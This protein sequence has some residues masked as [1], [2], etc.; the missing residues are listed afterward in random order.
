VVVDRRIAG[1]ARELTPPS[2][3]RGPPP[4][5]PRC[6]NSRDQD[7]QS[8]LIVDDRQHGQPGD[9]SRPTRAEQRDRPYRRCSPWLTVEKPS[10]RR[11]GT[12]GNGSEHQALYGARIVPRRNRVGNYQPDFS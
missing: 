8:G 6:R 11:D 5:E 12:L 10:A 9:Q 7:Q 3:P 2:L 1:E 4:Q